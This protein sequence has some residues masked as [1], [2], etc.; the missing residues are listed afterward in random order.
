[1]MRITVRIDD[2][3]KQKIKTIQQRTQF[4]TTDIIKQ[5]IDLL[6]EKAELSVKKQRAVG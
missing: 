2:S 3:Y 6:Y 5:A 1:M 4:N